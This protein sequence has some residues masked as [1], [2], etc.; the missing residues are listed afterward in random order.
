M[1][2][3]PAGLD[4]VRLAARV[5]ARRRSV[6]V[7]TAAG[8]AVALVI[9]F[10]LPNWFRAT[11]VLLPPDD[12]DL[13]SNLNM[14]HRALSKFPQFG[15]LGEYFTPADVFKA[16]LKSRMAGDYVVDRFDLQKVYKLKSRE[17]TLKTLEGLTNVTLMPD[18]TIALAVED[19]DPRRAA[20]MANAYAEILDR[21]NIEKRNTQA[22]RVRVFLERRMRETDSLLV[23]DERTLR[24]YQEEHK[25]VAP[26]ALG[27]SDIQ[28]AAD[29]L[30]RKLMLEVRL[31]VLRSYLREDDDQ[32]VRARTER[33]QL[34][35]QIRLL[36]SLETELTRLIRDYKVQ[37]QLYLLLSAELEQARIQEL[38]DTPTVT[39]LDAAIPPERKS[40]PKRS[41]IALIAG[42]LT[43]LGSVAYVAVR[44]EPAA[45][46]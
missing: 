15:Q 13:L 24:R 35:K 12:S 33:E 44:G 22:H 21:F 8:L 14:A 38:Q 11:V 6:I 40:R 30:S 42:M 23:Q 32:V 46:A 3:P 28:S 39:V 36:P 20:E 1:T 34:E 26:T 25:T 2:P 45:E 43:F 31:G 10:L 37:E 4:L 17:K 7:A 18:G 16:T 27:S 9:V 5:W 29:V 19:R 41:L